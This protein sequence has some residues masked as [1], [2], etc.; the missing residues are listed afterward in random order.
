MTA[1]EENPDAP[2]SQ[3]ILLFALLTPGFI[4]PINMV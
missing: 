1:D 4:L 2:A 3:L